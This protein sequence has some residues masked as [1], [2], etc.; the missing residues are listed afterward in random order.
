MDLIVADVDLLEFDAMY[1]I[2]P[3]GSISKLTPSGD[4][5]LWFKVSADEEGWEQ[6][7]GKHIF[8]V[9]HGDTWSKFVVDYTAPAVI[10][11]PGVSPSTEESITGVVEFTFGFKSATGNLQ[12]LE[13]DIY[14][15]ENA[16]KNRNYANH[17]GIN[18]P[19]G[20]DA[21]AAWVDEVVEGYSQLD[22]KFHGLLA[23]AGYDTSAEADANK[24]TLKSNIFYTGDEKAGTWTIKLDTAVLN[25]D[26]I[27]FLVAVKDDK[28]AQWGHNNYTAYPGEVKAFLYSV[29]LLVTN[30]TQNKSYGAIQAAITASS[31]R[32]HHCSCC[33]HV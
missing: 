31:C 24:E 5:C 28:G 10:A 15:G 19:A 32:R 25:V 3:G 11:D 12:E 33:R 9:K 1:Q 23:A 29:T 4:N 13:L 17:L 20:S 30:T 27:E 14:L 2:K 21:V 7:V 26:K 8:L 16:G 18:L 22:S 6:E